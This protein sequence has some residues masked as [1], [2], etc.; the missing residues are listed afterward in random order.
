M[1]TPELEVM[2]RLRSTPGLTQAD[3]A[4]QLGL[5][6]TALAHIMGKR[7]DMPKH[8]LAKLGLERVIRYRRV[9]AATNGA[10]A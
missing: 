6:P 1:L 3:L 4:R 2:N 7:R 5:D 10:T 9:K 8:A